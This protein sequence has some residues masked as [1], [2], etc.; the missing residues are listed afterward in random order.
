MLKIKVMNAAADAKTVM[1]SD[2]A[3]IQDTIDESGLS[4]SN[5]NFMLNGDSVSTAELEKPLNSFAC[6]NR[7][8]G[9][10]NVI[11]TVTNKNNA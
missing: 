1:M 9:K 8:D 2:E 3:T 6:L 5:C 11:S 10:I 7:E 4:F